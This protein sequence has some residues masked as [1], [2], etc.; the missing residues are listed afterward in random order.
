MGIDHGGDVSMPSSSCG[1][2]IA[3][4]FQKMGGEEVAEHMAGDTFGDGCLGGRLPDVRLS[5][6]YR[7]DDVCRPSTGSTPIW[8]AGKR[9][10]PNLF[11]ETQTYGRAMDLEAQPKHLPDPEY[12]SLSLHQFVHEVRELQTVATNRSIFTP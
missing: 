3:T 6:D 5:P 11:A 8:F 4:V 9:Y 1:T 7:D 10:C 12:A 2:N